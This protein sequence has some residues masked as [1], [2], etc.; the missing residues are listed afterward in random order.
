[1]TFFQATYHRCQNIWRIDWVDFGS[2]TFAFRTSCHS[3]FRHWHTLVERWVDNYFCKRNWWSPACRFHIL[4]RSY[5]WAAYIDSTLKFKHRIIQW[6]Y[7]SISYIRI[8]KHIFEFH[9]WVNVSCSVVTI[10]KNV[11]L[12]IKGSPIMFAKIIVEPSFD[13]LV[14]FPSLEHTG[15]RWVD[16]Y[17]CKHNWW[18]PAC[19]FHTLDRS[20]NWSAYIDSTLK[21]KQRIIRSSYISI[22]Y[23]R[24]FKP[25]YFLKWCLIFDDFYSTDCKT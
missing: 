9:V 4:D 11:K 6:S 14:L 1:M 23:V 24:I 5:N 13:Q 18:S 19:R 25:P 20:Y 8:F 16:N 21:F 7:I 15:R 2:H 3:C 22:W 17:F 12:T 10:V